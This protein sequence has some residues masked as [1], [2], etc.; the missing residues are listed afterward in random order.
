MA[1]ENDIEY[2]SRRIEEEREKA[3]H[4]SDPSAYRAHTEFA[5]EYE[6]KLLTLITAQPQAQLMN[7]HAVR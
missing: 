3:E 6:R 5:R 4:A 7:G 1:K 2:L